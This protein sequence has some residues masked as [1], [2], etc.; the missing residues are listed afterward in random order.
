VYGGA[1]CG[2]YRWNC[3]G[4]NHVDYFS[5]QALNIHWDA[6]NFTTIYGSGE[7]LPIKLMNQNNNLI[8]FINYDVVIYNKTGV[9]K[10]YHCLSNDDLSLDLLPGIYTVELTVTYPGL[11]K[12]EPK[13]ITLTLTDGTTF[14]DLKKTIND[15][16]N[17]TINLDK[18]YTFNPAFDSAFTNG[19]EITRP[20]TI[21][22]NGAVIDAKG[23]A[24]IFTVQSENVTF[25][26][27]TFKNGK[28]SSNFGGAIYFQNGGSLFDCIFMNNIAKI[29]GAVYFYSGNST[30]HR[31]TFINN[32]AY[33]S[34]SA[35]QLSFGNGSVIGCV[36]MDNIAGNGVV[37]TDSESH[38]QIEIANNIFLNNT[39]IMD[40]I[41][42]ACNENLTTD[43]NWF[44]NVA[45]DYG[46]GVPSQTS[47]VWLFLNATVD[48]NRIP[49]SD[50][51]A[52]V[53]R[54][55]AYNKTNLSAFDYDNSLLKP[56]YLEIFAINGTVDREAA[57]LEEK[58]KFTATGLGIGRVTARLGNVG[59]SVELE[60]IRANSTL[61]IDNN[62]T[63]DY[64]G[65]GSTEVSFT[66]ASGVNASVIG[67]PNAVVNVTGNTIT[68]SGLNPGNYTLSVTT[69][70]DDNHNNVTKT[71]NITV[72]KA[73]TEL[74]ADEIV[75]TYTINKDLIVTLKDAHGIVLTGAVVTVDL[76]GA[77]NYTTDSSGQVKISTKGLAANIYEVMI[78]FNGTDDYL[79]FSNTT[80]V[81]INKESAI[82]DTKPLTTDYNMHKYLVV[83]LKDN[84]G[85]PICNADAYI[86]IH[87]V[88]YKCRSD[89]KGDARLIIRLN[90]GTYTAKI[91][92]DN[93]NYTGFT[94]YITVIVKKLTPK[95]TA[96][97]KT[98]KKSKKVKKYTV[99]LK[100][101]NGKAIKKAKVTIKIGKKT[102]KAT[103]NAKGKAIFKIKK[104]TKK[105]KYKATVKY[106]GN[107]LY[108][109]VIKK[110]KITVK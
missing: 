51:S 9:V 28:P 34:Y 29:G 1:M 4:Q 59:Q 64:N 12:P 78:T 86:E 30:V 99:T 74:T 90:P 32:T 60:I 75:T 83:G 5:T 77:K 20:V 42:F 33:D 17:A 107:Y 58:V 106:N 24:K 84:E 52:I 38:G 2:G 15:N 10:T 102:Y 105:G 8:S 109:K 79:N 81:T 39:V 68:V 92:F 31:C 97:K 65:V 70:V 67:Q 22:G 35:I 73:K 21:N 36:F 53:F 14:S 25:K 19:I 18:N 66:N 101:N 11:D 80:K 47:N 26:N 89:E 85:N 100:D 7:T 63:F 16:A 104:L 76:N 95:L 27:I 40:V 87:G 45:G 103:T 50:S 93:V 98:F 62:I 82:I 44:G 94:Q 48:N 110:V 6:N 3:I 41:N 23:N 108:N 72:N 37:G 57:L 69:I 13:N 55:Y 91:T 56:V 49:I 46:N 88:T 54:L 96:K 71:V 61:T 43:Y